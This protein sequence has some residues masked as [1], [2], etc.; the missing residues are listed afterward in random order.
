MAQ[1]ACPKLDLEWLQTVSFLMRS[2]QGGMQARTTAHDVWPSRHKRDRQ[3]W[4]GLHLFPGW[5]VL[6]GA[7]LSREQLQPTRLLALCIADTGM[8]REALEAE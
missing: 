1:Q 4:A 8:A 3:T 5:S 6:C 7:C 2:L